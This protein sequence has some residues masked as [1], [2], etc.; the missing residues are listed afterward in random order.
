MQLYISSIYTCKYRINFADVIIFE[1]HHNCL[2]S[3]F[4]SNLQLCHYT[5][6]IPDD[7]LMA[8]WNPPPP[9]SPHNTPPPLSAEDPS[10][11][12]AGDSVGD[13][14]FSK[15]WVLS[16]LVMVVRSV[17][18]EETIANDSKMEDV[19]NGEQIEG[20]VSLESGEGSMASDS[21]SYC[22]TA[23]EETRRKSSDSS[24]QRKEGEEE[25]EEEEE[26]ISEDLENDLCRLWDVSVNHVCCVTHQVMIYVETHVWLTSSSNSRPYQSI[27]TL[28]ASM[29]HGRT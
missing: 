22:D 27:P 10:D 18:G 17:Q 15:S 16:L 21:S 12:N 6:K 9:S 11:G 24:V 1:K 13:T 29:Q 3:V 20:G 7:S 14:V 5:A 23:K 8:Q 4:P 26:A 28:V 25:E 2:S 19:S